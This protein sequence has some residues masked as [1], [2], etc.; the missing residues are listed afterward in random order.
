[1][2]IGKQRELKN[3]VYF[4]NKATWPSTMMPIMKSSEPATEATTTEAQMTTTEGKTF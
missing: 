1:M 2:I 4:T 3:M